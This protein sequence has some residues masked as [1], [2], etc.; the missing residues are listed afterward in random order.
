[1]IPAY[2]DELFKNVNSKTVNFY[3]SLAKYAKCRQIF[4]HSFPV[5]QNPKSLHDLKKG[6]QDRRKSKKI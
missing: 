1:M 4:K 6:I 3:D 2:I 5:I